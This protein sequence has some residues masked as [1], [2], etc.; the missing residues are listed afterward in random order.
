MKLFLVLALTATCLT[1]QAQRIT[2]KPVSA[3][4]PPSSPSAPRTTYTQIGNSIFG[5]DGTRAQQIGDSTVTTDG[6][7]Y[8]R[9]G[10]NTFGSDGS[11]ATTIDGN[12]I[13][14]NADGTT[15]K[16]SSVGSSSFCY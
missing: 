15:R 5:S 2:W 1:A 3:D 9:S 4:T 6:R 10:N 11:T 16:C 12:T 7:S 14:R 8:Y 13:I